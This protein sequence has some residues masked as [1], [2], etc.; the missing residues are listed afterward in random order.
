MTVD[1]M[2]QL[3]TVLS[4]GFASNLAK[5]EQGIQFFEMNQSFRDSRVFFLRYQSLQ[6]KALE[7]IKSH[8]TATLSSTAQRLTLRIGDLKTIRNI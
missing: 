8:I 3:F 4:L 2:S 7:I 1:L 5:I 6:S